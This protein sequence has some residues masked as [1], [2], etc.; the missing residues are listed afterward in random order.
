MMGFEKCCHS[1]SAGPAFG[2][3]AVG[4]YALEYLTSSYVAVVVVERDIRCVH[5]RK[6]LKDGDQEQPQAKAGTH[7]SCTLRSCDRD[8]NMAR[9][10]VL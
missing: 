6:R 4:L 3:A 8:K 7:A 9:R 1:K 10:M 2:V 5:E